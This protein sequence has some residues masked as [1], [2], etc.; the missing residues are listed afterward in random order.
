Y[1]ALISDI[2]ASGADTVFYGGYD[3]DFGKLLKQAHDAGLDVT[4]MSGD[5]SVSS[6]LLDT[7]G[8]GAEGV[9]LSIPSNIGEDIKEA[10]DGGA[11][12]A[13]GI[14][15]GIKDYLDSLTVD[16]PFQGEAKPIAF[17]DKHE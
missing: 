15:A 7:A 17:D 9:Y 2:E 16:N 14:R 5:G 13:V 8:D 6:T 12:D 4:W 3:A 11:T 10:I 1:S